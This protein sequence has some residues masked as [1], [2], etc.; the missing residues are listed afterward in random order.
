MDSGSA[1]TSPTVSMER[2][3]AS[4]SRMPSRLLSDTESAVSSEASS[5][6]R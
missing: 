6:A 4:S 1:K 5:A 2:P 3:A